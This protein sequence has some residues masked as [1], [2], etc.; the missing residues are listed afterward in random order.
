[1]V[2]KRRSK[3]DH[4]SNYYNLKF[5]LELNLSSINKAS[6]HFVEAQD[7]WEQDPF[8]E[9]LINKLNKNEQILDLLYEQYDELKKKMQANYPQYLE[10]NLV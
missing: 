9:E 6:K 4:K 3:M 2:S 7:A 1:V 10:W 5:V 8:N